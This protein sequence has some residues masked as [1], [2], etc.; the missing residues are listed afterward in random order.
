MCLC[1]TPSH[2]HLFGTL[3]NHVLRSL[4]LLLSANR[5][6]MLQRYLNT[7][8]RL[9]EL[10]AAFG[11][12]ILPGTGDTTINNSGGSNIDS[13]DSSSNNNNNTSNTNNNESNT[14]S[15]NN[16][17]N[18]NSSDSVHLEGG[19]NSIV[20]TAVITAGATAG[21]SAVPAKVGDGS[22]SGR[23]KDCVLTAQLEVADDILSR[24][25]GGLSEGDLL[26]IWERYV[27]RVDC[28]FAEGD[29]HA[30]RR[31]RGRS[32]Y[33]QLAKNEF[34]GNPRSHS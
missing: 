10:R 4:L 21:G 6:C 15:N 9:K 31:T 13:T 32:I 33:M 19:V 27:R 25:L 2:A 24:E 16:D 1:F 22:G 14:D 18:S 7:C 17:S 26:L 8:A 34:G 28:V 20:A 11:A 5:A 12:M 30:P 29:R 23:N 3:A